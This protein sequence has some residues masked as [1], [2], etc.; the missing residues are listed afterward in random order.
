MKN[1]LLLSIFSIILIGCNNNIYY[2]K[3]EVLHIEE[4]TLYGELKGAFLSSPSG[5]LE[6]DNIVSIKLTINQ[7][8]K[9]IDFRCSYSELSYIKVRSFIPMSYTVGWGSGFRRYYLKFNHRTISVFTLS[10]SSNLSI[11]EKL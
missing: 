6:Y 4:R 11:G 7:T 8:E 9:L 5:K 3:A 2:T 10:N 1:Y